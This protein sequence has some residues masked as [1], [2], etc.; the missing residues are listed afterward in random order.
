MKKL[1]VYEIECGGMHYEGMIWAANTG[2]ARARIRAEI[3]HA[4]IN[5]VAPYTWDNMET[6]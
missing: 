4:N 5:W 6:V 3:P 2:D 1:Y